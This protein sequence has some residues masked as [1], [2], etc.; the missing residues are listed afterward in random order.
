MFF[1]NLFSTILTFTSLAVNGS[2]L[3]CVLFMQR[4][5]SFAAHVVATSICSSVGQL[6]IFATIEEFGPVVFTI[7][8]TMRQ[9]FSILLSCIF[10]EHHLN[11]LAISGITVAFAAVFLHAFSQFRRS[12]QSNST[13]A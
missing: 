7:I 2:L 8:M 4:H 12:K 3:E 11:P 6:F 13:V 9:A 5:E 10:Y 1:V